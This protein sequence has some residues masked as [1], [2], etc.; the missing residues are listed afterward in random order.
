VD[1]A[2]GVV[3]QALCTP[4]VVTSIKWVVTLVGFER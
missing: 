1:V 3:I 4:A 2:E